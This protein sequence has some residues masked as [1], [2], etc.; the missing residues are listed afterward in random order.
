MGFELLHIYTP[1]E[2]DPKSF[3]D[4]MSSVY[5]NQ[6]YKYIGASYTND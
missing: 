6:K 5:L 3:T 1:S 2:S 4:N